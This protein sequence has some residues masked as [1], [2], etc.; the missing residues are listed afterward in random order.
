MA[1]T[2][3]ASVIS[4]SPVSDWCS[5][6]APNDTAPPETRI[7]TPLFPISH[8]AAPPEVNNSFFNFILEQLPLMNNNSSLLLL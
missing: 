3:L 4:A 2:P 5:S 6:T 7:N 1:V 8:T